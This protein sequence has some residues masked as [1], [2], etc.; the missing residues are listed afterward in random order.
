MFVFCEKKR[1]YSISST[2]AA[3]EHFITQ[4]FSLTLC[5]QCKGTPKEG[6]L[7]LFYTFKDFRCLHKLGLS[8]NKCFVA[9]KMK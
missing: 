7:S 3:T 1:N 5:M 9:V 8:L 2:P 6:A 4:L